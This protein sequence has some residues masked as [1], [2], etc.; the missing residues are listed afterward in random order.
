LSYLFKIIGGIGDFGRGTP[1][2]NRWVNKG[3]IKIKGSA[4]KGAGARRAKK[5]RIP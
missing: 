2:K 3:G 5:I 4:P 1:E